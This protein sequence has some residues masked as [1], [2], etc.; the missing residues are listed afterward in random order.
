MYKK[1]IVCIVII[2]TLFINPAI[3]D[4]VSI[5]NGHWVK[6]IYDELS[7]KKIVTSSDGIKIG[8]STNYKMFLTF[9]QRVESNSRFKNQGKIELVKA[10]D[11][12]ITRIDAVKL[13]IQYLG[14][15]WLAQQLRTTTVSFDDVSSDKGYVQLAI[16]FGIISSKSKAFRPNDTLLQEEAMAL[17]YNLQKNKELKISSIYSYYA[18]NSYNQIDK[19]KELNSVILGWSRIEYSK[20]S[21][22]IIINTSSQNNNEYR[23]PLGYNEVISS[24]EK[25]KLNKYLMV[26]VR[27]ERVYDETSK[28]EV[29]LTE[30]LINNREKTIELI[31]SA[32]TQNTQRIKYDGV[33]IDFENLRGSENAVKLNL[34][35]SNLR[36][37]LDKEGMKMM[38]AV[39]PV[40]RPGLT[41][42]DGYDYR[43]I[44]RLADYVILMAHD[45]YPKKLTSHEME[46]GFT[47]TPLLAINDLYFALKG[48]TDKNTGVV[49]RDKIILQ[50]SMDSVQWKL[51][52]GV[53]IN[54]KP[55]NPT[56]AAIVNRI[57]NGV[58]I[59]YSDSMK[60]PY[61]V[62][63]DSTDKTRNIVWYEDERSIQAKLDMMKYFGIKNVSIWRLGT[64]SDI[65]RLVEEKP[66]YLNLWKQILENR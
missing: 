13:C 10:A 32:L 6:S 45:F 30:Y 19:F 56:Y 64:I 29:L 14:Y 46:S 28:K 35:L 42:Y 58:P 54:E 55:Y 2:L 51:N 1:T 50:F 44:G 63:E 9:I 34:F 25:S 21:S 49:D 20:A 23:I 66:H 47:I 15:D 36:V 62:F 16:D 43:S 12:A 41:Y 53:I 27:D 4:T 52:N 18:I 57:R 31:M 17:I 59:I 11:E 22:S 65:E 24:A 40:R 61:I 33:L 3:A 7:E 26:A 5:P 60:S 37:A 8:Q 38:V 48:I 39:H